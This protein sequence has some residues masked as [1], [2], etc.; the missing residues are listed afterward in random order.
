M[1]K[2]DA[3]KCGCELQGDHGHGKEIAF[4]LGGLPVRFDDEVPEVVMPRLLFYKIRDM[5]SFEVKLDGR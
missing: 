1:A 2:C 5:V 3:G 4:T